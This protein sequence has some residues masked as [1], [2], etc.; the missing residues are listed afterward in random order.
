MS[1]KLPALT[2][3]LRPA[4]KKRGRKPGGGKVPGSGRKPGGKNKIPTD[5]RSVIL[6]RGKPLELL[7]DISRGVKIRVGPQAGP[8]EAQYTYPTLQERAAAAKILIDKLLPAASVDSSTGQPMADNADLDLA[9]R[10]GKLDIAKRL[11]F[12]LKQGTQ[13]LD[14]RIAAGEAG[15]NVALLRKGNHNAG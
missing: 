4:P 12:V 9:T 3:E 6:A 13:A 14:E 5:M 1:E 8:S 7:C 2:D 11:A 15:E 10:A